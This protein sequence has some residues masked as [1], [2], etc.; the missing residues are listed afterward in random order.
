[1]QLSILTPAKTLFNGEV[2][3]VT[4]PGTLGLFTVL[5]NHAPAISSLRKGGK[6]TYGKGDDT[7]TIEIDGGFAQVLD[8]VVT[9][10]VETHLTEDINPVETENDN[11]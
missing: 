8:N 3:S 4:L 11:I 1:M 5:N 7:T 2:D 6:I 9:V 10:C